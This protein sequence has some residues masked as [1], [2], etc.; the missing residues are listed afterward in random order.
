MRHFFTLLYLL[1]QLILTQQIDVWKLLQLHSVSS[2]LIHVGRR[3]MLDKWLWLRL[4]WLDVAS[5][6]LPVVER[7]TDGVEFLILR[8]WILLIAKGWSL[9]IKTVEL[10][11][12][13]SKVKGFAQRWWL[14]IIL[15]TQYFVFIR[16]RRINSYILRPLRVLKALLSPVCGECES[17]CD[18]LL[19]LI[20]FLEAQFLQ[21]LR[22]DIINAHTFLP[23]RLDVEWGFQS[24]RVI[25]I[26]F[27]YIR[28]WFVIVAHP[29]I[30]MVKSFWL[31]ADDVQWLEWLQ[32]TIILK[33]L[34]QLQPISFLYLFFVECLI[35][36]QINCL[37]R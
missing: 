33:I 13:T 3:W 5:E 31:W 21:L 8:Y 4:G 22:L 35:K 10:L 19:I 37:I 28:I 34:L 30:H 20:T 23:L 16:L 14:T 2:H 18:L 11:P 17:F 12:P 32:I 29:S 7:S 26:V 9:G 1:S 27:N 6:W 25:C 15:N 36:S 24:I